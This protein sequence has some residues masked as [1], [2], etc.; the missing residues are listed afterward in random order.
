ML[1]PQ[2][3]AKVCLATTA[4]QSVLG[5]LGV[6]LVAS[7]RKQILFMKQILALSDSG[8][9]RDKDMCARACDEYVVFLKS[10]RSPQAD[11]SVPSVLVD[12][13]WHTHMGFPEHYAADCLRICGFE[14]DH[15]VL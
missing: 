7:S 15:V 6:D 4:D 9:A 12:H 8:S 1:H 13:I 10:L 14:V 11:R 3:Y 2:L 5:Y